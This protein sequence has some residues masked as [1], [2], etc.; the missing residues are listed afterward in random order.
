MNIKLY[1]RYFKCLNCNT[2]FHEECNFLSSP[3]TMTIQKDMKIL[4]ALKDINSTFKS[5]AAR[6]EVSDTYV[7]NIFDRKVDISR[8]KLPKILCVD[9]VYSKKL[10][11]HKYCFILYAPQLKKIVDVL[12]SRH[13]ENLEEYFHKIPLNERKNV[14][15]FSIDLYDTYRAIGKKYF[16]N[17]IICADSFHVIKNLSNFLHKI[18]IR[19][20]HKFENLKYSHDNYY[21]LLKRYPK[22]LTRDKSKLGYTKFKVNRQG[23]YMNEHEIVEYILSLDEQLKKAYNIYQEYLVFN[24]IATI[25][26]AEQWLNQ[27]IDDYKASNITEYV[28]AWKLLENWHDEIINSFNRVNG[29]RISN[30]PM[31]RVNESIKTIFR[32]SFGSR[33]F[34]RMRNRIMYVINDNSAIL[35]ARKRETNKYKGKP[36][37]PYNKN[38]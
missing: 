25:D 23:Q 12:D 15:F 37:G 28:P 10:S 13:K 5:V 16:P 22:L 9:E 19:I 1:R 7:Q 14:Q 21:W 26:M 8:L 38:K 4:E 30:G 34:T 11:Y 33:N 2:L 20:M 18:R 6:F 17:A 24:Q 32:L 27:L 31:E 29:Y 35:Y 3:K 36:R